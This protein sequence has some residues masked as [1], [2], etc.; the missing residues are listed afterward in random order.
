MHLPGEGDRATTTP[1]EVRGGAG[2]GVG[3]ERRGGLHLVGRGCRDQDSGRGENPQ[4]SRNRAHRHG[5]SRPP[6]AD[7]VSVRGAFARDTAHV[8]ARAEHGQASAS[9][10]PTG[11]S[12]GCLR[13]NPV[14]VLHAEPETRAVLQADRPLDRRLQRGSRAPPR[15]RVRRGRP[16]RPVA[17]PLVRV[18]HDENRAAVQPPAEE[19]LP[20]PVEKRTHSNITRHRRRAVHLEV[21]PR[22]RRELPHARS[23]AQS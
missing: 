1:P 22:D 19:P 21:R 13:E 17:R 20:I 3:D 23:R 14:Q 5:D 16:R 2:R 9:I 18:L 15:A 10:V 6:R 8:H 11:G 12:E 4:R 7:P